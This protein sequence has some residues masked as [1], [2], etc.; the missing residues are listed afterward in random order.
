MLAEDTPSLYLAFW[1]F[2][3]LK[4]RTFQFYPFLI[5]SS[6]LSS[7]LS[8]PPHPL[9]SLKH[10][11]LPQNS[12]GQS[13]V[14]LPPTYLPNICVCRHAVVWGFSTKALV[15]IIH[16]TYHGWEAV[17]LRDYLSFEN[18]PVSSTLLI[19]AYIALSK[20]KTQ[21]K[22]STQNPV[23]L[24]VSLLALFLELSEWWDIYFKESG[25]EIYLNH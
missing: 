20:N 4:L 11:R 21:A 8:V 3:I 13:G 7:A 17:V 14:S 6:I 15:S 1:L 19:I 24:Q 18:P 23:I 16:F 25:R 5:P 2:L 12:E 10:V 9:H 22:T